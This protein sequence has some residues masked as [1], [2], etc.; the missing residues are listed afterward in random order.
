MNEARRI[1]NSIQGKDR[2]HRHA[3]TVITGTL[4]GCVTEADMT[5]SK[6]AKNA[7]KRHTKRRYKEWQD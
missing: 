3:L 1:A 2:R 7:L 6:R 4:E 5:I